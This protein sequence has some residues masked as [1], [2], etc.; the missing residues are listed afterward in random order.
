MWARGGKGIIKTGGYG[1]KMGG[2]ADLIWS[3]GGYLLPFFSFSYSQ[4]VLPPIPPDLLFSHP[5]RYSNFSSLPPI[6]IPYP[7]FCYSNFTPGFLFSYHQFVIPTSDLT[8]HLAELL[9][10][11]D[12]PLQELL[13]IKSFW[14]FMH[15]LY[16]WPYHSTQKCCVFFSNR[17][18][19]PEW[20][21]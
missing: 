10:I 3:F 14:K 8:P 5:V 18:A 2:H 20:K 11:T 9:Y 7:T 15:Y 1:D 13:H 21:F 19:K 16:S 4:F 12:T 17:S 6:L